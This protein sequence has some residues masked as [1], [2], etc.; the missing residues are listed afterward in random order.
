MAISTVRIQINGTWYDLTYNSSTGKYEK[1][2][3]APNTTSYNVNS[4]HYYAVTVEATNSAGTKVTANDNTANIG[5]SLKLIV[6]ERVKP[7]ISITSPGSGA[8]VSNANQPI[9]FQVRDESVGSGVDI[10]KLVLKIDGGAAITNLSA[11]MVCTQVA[12]GYDC[13]YTPQS[14]LA[15]GSHT[16]TIDISDFDG[17]SAVQASRTFKIDTVPPVLNIS[18]PANNL[19][20]NNKSLVIQGTTNDATSTTVTINI[21]LNNVDQGVVPVTSGSF[22]K[23]ITLIEGANT[24]VITATDQANKTTS[25]TLNVTADTSIPVISGVTI[26]PNP[27][28][29]GATMVIS[30]TV[31]G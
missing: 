6:K 16:V 8:F 24:I 1:T 28:D 30:I 31:T 9:V 4:G 3:T 5:N 11:G 7:T 23:T 12:N 14:S 27:A 21:K 10:S 18:S 26:T 22:T 19:I 13:T 29:A 20:T 2:I 17:N 15:D 25:T